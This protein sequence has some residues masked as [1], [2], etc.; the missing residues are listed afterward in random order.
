LKAE[1]KE[2]ML[3]MRAQKKAM[4]KTNKINMINFVVLAAGLLLIAL[5]KEE[6]GNYVIWACAFVFIVTGLSSILAATSLRK[7][8]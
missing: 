3:K 5:G 2:N 7:Q 6:I 8:K 1:K 4:G